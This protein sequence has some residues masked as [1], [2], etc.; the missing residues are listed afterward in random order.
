MNSLFLNFLKL[1]WPIMAIKAIIIKF[2]YS[3]LSE[4][5]AGPIWTSHNVETLDFANIPFDLAIG[6][7]EVSFLYHAFINKT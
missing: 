6:F 3:R 2:D 5:N 7:S 1:L 4:N